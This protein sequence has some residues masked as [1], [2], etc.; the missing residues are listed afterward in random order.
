VPTLLS[1]S[2][3]VSCHLELRHCMQIDDKIARVGRTDVLLYIS[4]NEKEFDEIKS[5]G[6]VYFFQY[7]ML[8]INF[9]IFLYNFCIYLIEAIDMLDVTTHCITM[10]IEICNVSIA[11]KFQG[12][13]LPG[14]S[15]NEADKREFY[16]LPFPTFII[17]TSLISL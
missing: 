9:A 8:H 1:F 12:Q 11:L 14:I 5:R 3:G 4:K 10:S 7:S 6:E 15:V 17:L 16:R 2:L 13:T